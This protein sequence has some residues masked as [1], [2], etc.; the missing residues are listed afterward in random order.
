MKTT[1]TVKFETRFYPQ[2]CWVG[3][4]WRMR[5]ASSLDGQTSTESHYA[6]TEVCVCIIPCLVFII[7]FYKPLYYGQLASTQAK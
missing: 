4:S 7:R 2:L 1:K 5:R 6:V 3:F